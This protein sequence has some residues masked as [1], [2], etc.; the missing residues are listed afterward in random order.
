[1]K[2]KEE[3]KNQVTMV[4]R[5]N[6]LVILRSKDDDQTSHNICALRSLVYPLFAF[7]RGTIQKSL[8]I[9]SS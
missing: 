2:L 9:E 7:P 1:M 6:E 8:L 5:T 3:A 4:T